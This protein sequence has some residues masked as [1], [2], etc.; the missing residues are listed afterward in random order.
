MPSTQCSRCSKNPPKKGYKTC[1][2]CLQYN[3]D[4]R[5]V[6]PNVPKKVKILR[7]RGVTCGRRHCSD[8]GRWRPLVDFCVAKWRDPLE[9]TEPQY[10]RNICRTCERLRGRVR[11][12]QRAGRKEPYGPQKYVGQTPEERKQR[13]LKSRRDWQKMKLETDP[14]WAERYREK[15]RFYAEKRRRERGVQPL[16]IEKSTYKRSKNDD[17]ISIKPFQQW[18]ESRIETY[19]SIE[20]FAIAVDTS[21][22]TVL[23]WRTGREIDKRGK[24]R[25]FDKIPLHTVDVA[26]TREGNTALWEVYPELYN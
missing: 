26:L 14:E 15:Q 20:D 16:A 12:A 2:K 22:R 17:L 23:R 10:F 6:N 4:Y 8:C 19:G 18:I 7:K 1:E 3:R 25:I 21:P 9:R 5:S 13:R 11:N 24:E